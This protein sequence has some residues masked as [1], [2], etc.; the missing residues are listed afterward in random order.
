MVA[1]NPTTPS[2]RLRFAEYGSLHA[3]RQSLL[4]GLVAAAILSVTLACTAFVQAGFWAI[5]ALLMG[6][7]FSFFEV[8]LLL[9]AVMS[10]LG[11]TIKFSALSLQ[12]IKGCSLILL[13]P[14]VRNR[15]VRFT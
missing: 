4:K 15:A 13:G 3:R 9:S 7:A 5:I 14:T 10:D 12:T 11:K 2:R 1:D 6:F 8:S